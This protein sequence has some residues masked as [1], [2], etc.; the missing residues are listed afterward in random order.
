MF[1]LLAGND[2]QSNRQFR[3]CVLEVMHK[4]EPSRT[5]MRRHNRLRHDDE[6]RQGIADVHVAYR[7]LHAPV[8][9]F[10]R[11]GTKKVLRLKSRLGLFLEPASCK[12]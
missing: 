6:S 7:V 9:R 12:S 2:I 3:K 1:Y 10:S 5:V 8:P 4:Y 11:H